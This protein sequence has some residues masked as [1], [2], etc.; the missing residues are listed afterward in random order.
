MK[1]L[2]VGAG[3]QGHVLTWHLARC[4][5]VSEIFLGDVNTSRARFVAAQ[6]GD[7]KTTPL[8]LDAADEGAVARAARECGLVVNAVVP[9][10]NMS[11]MR[12]CLAAGAHYQ[13]M[14]S[15]QTPT[16]TIDE[17]FLEQLTLS[18]QYRAAGLCALISTGMDPGVTNTLAGNGYEDLD[19]CVEIRLKDYSVLDSPV[20]LQVWSQEAYYLDC[21]QP[22]LLFEEG[23][24]TRVDPFSRREWYQFPEPFG[25]GLTVCH[26]HEEVSTL[27][28][29]LPTA[30][31]DKGLRYVDFKMG[32]PEQDLIADQA[33]TASGATSKHPVTLRDGVRVRPL[34]VFT[35]T[36]PPNPAP[37]ELA[38]L[39]LSGQITD[40]GVIAVDCIGQRAGKPAR[41]TYI[42]IP[43]DIRWVNE[44]IPGATMVSYGT[45]TP[46]AI[47]AQYLVQ[48]RIR[49]T[50]VIAPEVLAR[51]VRDR[52][53][54]DLGRRQIIVRRREEV[55]VN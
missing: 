42:V 32:M 50:G 49:Q 33:L 19:Q 13:D 40:I 28:R 30:F 43:P 22:P 34:D 27:P 2:I 29:L 45:S 44:L 53:I 25:R 17:A 55:Q 15:G 6:V 12:A 20:P 23:Q 41:I 11:I 14:A 16:Q 47:Y 37:H 38:R 9:Q 26:D 54:L 21:A 1:I 8:S 18:G 48:G 51:S 36:L 24:F 31:G 5:D 3:M 35:A 46:A 10:F 39:A 52:F 7:G 4:P